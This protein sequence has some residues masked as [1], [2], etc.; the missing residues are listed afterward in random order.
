VSLGAPAPASWADRVA[1]I[2]GDKTCTWGE[3]DRE[4]ARV[5]GVLRAAGVGSGDR[6]ALMAGRSLATIAGLRGILQ[7]GA[8]AV[9]MEPHGALLR[10]VAILQDAD[11]KAVLVG[12]KA[13]RRSRAVAKRVPVPFLSLDAESALAAA[14]PRTDADPALI[15]Y[16]SGSTGRPKGV[17]L[18]H[19]AVRHFARWA[20]ATLGLSDDDRVAHL[21][22]LTFDLCT[23][24]LFA[25]AEVGATTVVVPSGATMFPATLV[26]VLVDGACT[27][28]YTVPS[29]WTR[30]LEAELAPLA[31]GPLRHIV[32]AGEPFP[33]AALSRLMR[34][35]PGRPVHNFFGPTETNVCAAHRLERP[36][37]DAVPIGR[38]PP[39]YDIE[40]RPD[41]E[42]WVSGPGLMLGY[43]GRPELN[44]RAFTHHDGKLWLKTGD[45]VRR[46][47][48]G[49]LHA[50]GRLDSMLKH[51]GFRVQPEEVEGALTDHEAVSAARVG[52]DA[53][54][55]LVADVVVDGGQ[56][57]ADLRRHLSHRLPAHMI[58]E[59]RVVENLPR[60]ARGKVDRSVP[61]K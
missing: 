23:L 6:V 29:V 16:T 36:P 26:Q 20:A 11:V 8:V 40:V 45:R 5:V 39:Y 61:F 19:T 52:L 33:P 57:P 2:D 4:A 32:Y 46:D 1:V 3:L 56:L 47:P 15:L 21:S 10:Q 48:D 60:T 13:A 25:T 34:A 14:V 22:P 27:V 58:P 51:K 24:E 53:D 9:P 31:E 17:V 38:P 55:R 37:E 44:A 18:S 49:T 50:L 54:K 30:L 59:L 42:L 28:I 12:R 35:L 7:A 43:R 41:G